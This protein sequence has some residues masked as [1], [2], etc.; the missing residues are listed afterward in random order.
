M[1]VT[2][3]VDGVLKQERN[4]AQWVP[5]YTTAISAV[6]AVVALIAV[7]QYAGSWLGLI[8]F[9]SA[10]VIVELVGVELFAKSRSAM[11]MGFV[12]ALAA[13]AALGPW[14]GGLTSLA[15][16][17][18]TMVTTSFLSH[19]QKQDRPRASLLRRSAF[20]MSIR[21]LSATSAGL[22]YVW[23][24][25]IPGTPVAIH[26]FLPL[27]LAVVTDTVVGL[28]LL[29]IVIG[30]QTGRHPFQIWRQDWQWT[31]PIAIV[32]GVVGGG[33]LSFAYEVAGGT[34]MA[35]F[36]LPV[37]ATGYA[38]RLY[39]SHTRTYVDQ[40]EA[41]NQ[42]LE[43]TNLDLLHTLS[44]VIDAYDIYTFGHS[45]QVARY[46]GAIAQE[47]NL[48]PKEQAMI[49]RGAL[50]HDIGK[51]GV[52]DAIVGKPDRLT[53][54][55][56]EVMKLHTVIGAEIVAQMPQLQELI[57]MV[58]S[59]HE[60]WDGRGYPDGL[61]GEENSLPARVLA[62]A[63]SVEAM[64]S[65]RPY[66]ATRSLLDVVQE[67][68]RCSGQQFDPVIVSAF[69]RVVEAQDTDFFI[70][71]AAKVVQELDCRGLAE[72][73]DSHNHAKKSVALRALKTPLVSLSGR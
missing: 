41:A 48:P 12:I 73:Q 17:A 57:P 6:G 13:M 33:A 1:S 68:K 64:L 43:A 63:D 54:E 40:L 70:N 10:A 62:V 49:V 47:M 67:V 15:A 21:L 66:R 58:R 32:S 26:T 44:S 31:T 51:V 35:I 50:I 45:T 38:F 2:T 5:I 20:N 25:G 7:T 61:K 55:E 19:Y 29:I 30:L 60:R 72:N 3:L 46:A 36:M 14:A 8:L 52:T 18:A 42:K 56:F 37:A 53:D 59:H 39:I 28:G 4:T 71:S 65:D 27:F 16:G 69:L 22:I 23:A 24:G 9:V 34:G 11:S